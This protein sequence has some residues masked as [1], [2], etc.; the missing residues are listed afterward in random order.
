MQKFGRVFRGRRN[1]L[2]RA[3]GV[4]ALAVPVAFGLAHA[5]PR[6]A[7]SQGQNAATAAPV[8]DVASIKLNKGCE[9]RP[10]SAYVPS[11]G[12]LNL[13]CINLELAIQYAYSIFAN[14]VSPNLTLVQVS[15]GPGW[16][17]SDYY[18][19]IAKVDGN[20]RMTQMEGPMLR[21]LLEDRFQLKVHH[22]TREVPVYELTVAK[23]GLKLK[24]SM[25]G[26][27][28]PL[29][30][31]NAPP[32]P[33]PG[34]PPPNFCGIQKPGMKGGNITMD[35]NGMTMAQLTEGLLSRIT[36]RKVIDKTGLAGM[37]DVHLEFTPDE[38]TPLGADGATIPTAGANDLS[39]FNAL[40]EQLGLK[41]EAGRG[42]IDVFVI[43]R[44]ERP[45]GN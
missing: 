44:V 15:G 38:R 27:C 34:Q 4:A 18:E 21:A 12:E 22:D 11:R 9:A 16:I 33:A 23:G 3:A 10:R 19:I 32:P 8:F 6:Q 25:E 45:S 24:P 20:P 14:G 29:D 43:D 41:L 13:V 40:Q 7:Q 36:D 31:N 37:F 5:E 17:K 1:L 2:L 30:L 39:I 35:A 42:P 26:N 28:V